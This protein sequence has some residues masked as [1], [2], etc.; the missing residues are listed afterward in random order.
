MPVPQFHETREGTLFFRRQ[1]P[2]LIKSLTTIGTHLGALAQGQAAT[3]PAAGRQIMVLPSVDGEEYAGAVL[4]PAGLTQDEAID[5]ARAELA[6]LYEAD[7]TIPDHD[8]MFGDLI[9]A[10]EAKGFKALPTII[11]PIWDFPC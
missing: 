11:G 10:L 6:R 2:E 9:A 3:E 5:I 4:T 1:L 7:A 8:F